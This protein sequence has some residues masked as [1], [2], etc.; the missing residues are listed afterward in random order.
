MRAGLV[1]L[2][3][4]SWPGAVPVPPSRSMP[5]SVAWSPLSWL[6][7]RRKYRSPM[8]GQSI[9]EASPPVRI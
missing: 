7:Y 8:T 6:D 5:W 3:C 2:A 4:E 9:S 1:L